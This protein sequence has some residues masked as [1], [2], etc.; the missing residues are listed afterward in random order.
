M[1]MMK[2]KL[3]LVFILTTLMMNVQGQD[4]QFKRAFLDADYYLIEKKYDLALQGFAKLLSGDPDNGNLNYLCAYCL[5]KTN[6]D[7]DQVIELLLKASSFSDRSHRDGSYR[8]RHAPMY[9]YF[10]LGRAY[11]LKGQF[12]DAIESYG[13]YLSELDQRDIEE[14][15]YVDAHI[16]ACEQ[17]KK[18]ISDPVN[19]EYLPFGGNIHMEG[20]IKNPVISGNRYI[21]IFLT[22]RNNVTQIMDARKVGDTWSEPKEIEPQSG[23]TGSVFPVSLSYDGSELYLVYDDDSDKDIY[24]SHYVDNRWSKMIK[25]NRHINS[26]FDE[27]HASISADGQT[28]IFTS[29]RRRGMGGLD[30]YYANRIN[31]DKWDKAVN[32]GYPINTEYD[33]GTPFVTADDNQIYFSSQGHNTMGGYDIFLC[34]RTEGSWDAPYNIG[35]PLNTTGDD[36]FFNPDWGTGPPLYA[37]S[38]NSTDG[39]MSLYSVRIFATEQVAS[40]NAMP[41]FRP[42]QIQRPPG[43]PTRTTR[44]EQTGLSAKP[45]SDEE[46]SEGKFPTAIER[47]NVINT[48]LFDFNESGINEQSAQEL[49]RIYEL[50]EKYP[51]IH[52]E[53]KGRTDSRGNPD[54]NLQLSEKRAQS[55]A[56]YLVSKGIDRGRITVEAVGDSDPVA[57][58]HNEDGSDAPE[59]RKLNRS[60]SIILHTPNVGKISTADTSVPDIPDIKADME[61]T[62]LMFQST[63][64]VTS[65]PTE[66]LDEQVS[67]LEKDDTYTYTLGKFATKDDASSYLNE[68]IGKGYPD[69]QIVSLKNLDHLLQGHTLTNLQTNP[70]CFTIEFIELKYPQ[71]ASAFSNLSKVKGYKC[72]DGLYRFVTGEYS[73]YEDAKKHLAEVLHQGYADA[74][75]MPCSYFSNMMVQDQTDE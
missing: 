17:A 37:T 5:M 64:R 66:L 67:M 44:N 58:N 62:I 61:Y 28:L 30:I 38:I 18:M 8:E 1:I 15:N 27:T 10:L 69:A 2:N 40:V 60:V 23:M 55:A 25:L 72:K 73:G 4:R 42:E 63:G 50:L 59:G 33:E 26:R 75:V 41:A 21:L 29:D 12:D 39:Y 11:H 6:G 7:L 16:Y 57:S 65:T 24:V 31:G 20:N 47:S 43:P 19:V 70:E 56:E 13:R 22:E 3:L 52:I 9:T 53:L 74:M 14:I 68:V 36:L 45:G 35:Y 46:M 32:I 34:N 54:Y 49:D 71:D 51:D 48:I